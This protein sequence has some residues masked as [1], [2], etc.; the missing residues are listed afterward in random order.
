MNFAYTTQISIIMV[1]YLISMVLCEHANIKISLNG[2][3]LEEQRGKPV[4]KSRVALLFRAT[5]GVAYH[6]V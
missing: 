3:E 2:K 4:E 1:F 6:T 5:V